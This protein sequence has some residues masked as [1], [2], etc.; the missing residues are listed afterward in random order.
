M[1]DG[2]DKVSPFLSTNPIRRSENGNFSISL[3]LSLSLSL[4]DHPELFTVYIFA[5]NLSYY[6]QKRY[7]P[8]FRGFFRRG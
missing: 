2:K 6:I 1:K 5:K 4:R 7:I 8:D 3:S